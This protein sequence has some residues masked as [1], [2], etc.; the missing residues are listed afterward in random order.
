MANFARP[1]QIGLA[2]VCVGLTLL[3][4]TR[5]VVSPSQGEVHHQTRH[6]I[7]RRAVPRPT[8]PA[9]A[10][11]ESQVARLSPKQ[12]DEF[13]K[14]MAAFRASHPDLSADEQLQQ[15]VRLVGSRLDLR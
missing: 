9:L 4:M 15:R 10:G 2:G 5:P 13:L 8:L 12:V 14:K 7:A 3:V 1:V 11:T 6:E